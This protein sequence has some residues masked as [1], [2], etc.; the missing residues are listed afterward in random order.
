MAEQGWPKCDVDPVCRMDLKDMHGKYP[1]DFE[2]EVYYFCSE[3][4]RDK[5][6][7]QP[8][9]YAKKREK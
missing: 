9:K 2:N 1:Y 8:G 7:A 5:F 4:C 6:A 3:A